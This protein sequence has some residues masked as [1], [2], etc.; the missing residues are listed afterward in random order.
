VD[1]FLH[2]G[3]IEVHHNFIKPEGRIFLNSASNGNDSVNATEL[4]KQAP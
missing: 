2:E 4:A 1:L 3:N